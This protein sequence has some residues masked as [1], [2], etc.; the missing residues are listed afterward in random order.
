MAWPISDR[1]RSALAD[2]LVRPVLRVDATR[3]GVVVAADLH[4]TG[5]SVRV[6][7]SADVRRTC[8]LTVVG[9]PRDLVPSSRRRS[10]LDIYGNELVVSQGVRYG[11][12]SVEMVP[13]G[14]FVIVDSRVVDTA[15]GVAVT[16]RGEDRAGRI[17]RA[18]FLSPWATADGTTIADAITALASDRLPGIEVSMQLSAGGVTVPTHVVEEQA[19]PWADGLAA[20]A[21]A[22]GGEV[23]IDR[24]G[25]LVARDVP[26]LSGLP[27]TWQMA[28]GEGCTVTALERGFSTTAGGVNAVVVVG[29]S[30]QTIPVRG[31]ALDLDPESPTYYYGP[32]GPRPVWEQ[33]PLATTNEQA[34]LIAEAR[35]RDL[36]GCTEQVRVSCV[37]NPAID[38]GDLVHVRR[39][40]SDFDDVLVVDSYTLPLGYDGVMELDCWVR[41]A[42]VAS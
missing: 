29:E 27:A 12:G 40:R 14:V 30:V 26:D 39:L 42:V 2:G 32:F 18:K 23:F 10:P 24:V 4:V 1:M 5:G 20:L 17:D 35:G 28:E 33:T 19:S 3:E 34:Q 41:R 31:V 6:D 13:L 22:A 11:D 15:D 21:E 16:V 37:P 7:R 25:R 36:F 38:E 8:E 9:V